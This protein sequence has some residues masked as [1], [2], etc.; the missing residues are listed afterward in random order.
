MQ[1][2]EF[3]PREL[4]RGASDTRVLDMSRILGICDVVRAET[5]EHLG[6]EEQSEKYYVRVAVSG[7]ELVPIERVPPHQAHDFPLSPHTCEQI[8]M[9]E[10]GQFPLDQCTC[11]K[12]KFIE[13]ADRSSRLA[14]PTLLLGGDAFAAY[15]KVHHSPHAGY[16]MWGTRHRPSARRWTMSTHYVSHFPIGGVLPPHYCCAG[17]C[18]PGVDPAVAYGEL[19]RQAMELQGG[20]W[21]DLGPTVGLWFVFLCI[22]VCICDNPEG[23]DVSGKP[24]AGA[25]AK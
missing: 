9:A 12:C 4:V 10:R 8:E 2:L 15:S 18:P 21:M 14:R 22:L 24:S 5:W 17:L 13:S 7:S 19:A 16:A 20:K 25:A 11:G 6:E 1:N 3:L 23:Q